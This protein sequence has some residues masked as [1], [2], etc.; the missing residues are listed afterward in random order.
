[1]MYIKCDL[2]RALQIKRACIG[3]IGIVFVMFFFNKVKN[4]SRNIPVMNEKKF[5]SGKTDKM[6]HGWGLENVKQ[7]VEE[8]NGELQCTCENGM[9]IVNIIFYGGFK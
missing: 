6:K 8:N 9:F 7:I 5:L 2:K 1:M 3:S 4:A